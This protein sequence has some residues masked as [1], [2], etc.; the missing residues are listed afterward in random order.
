DVRMGGAA[1]Y[2]ERQRLVYATRSFL[3]VMDM[4]IFG[5]RD[6]AERRSETNADA[7]LWFFPR[8]G[9]AGIIERHPGGGDGELRVA[10]EALQPM[11][12][13]MIFRDPIP[14]FTAAMRIELGRIEA[15]DG[16]NAAF[17]RAE[18]APKV[19]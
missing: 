12:R 19:F 15:R 2:L 1:E 11:G 9:N 13:K 4:L 3:E 10:V 17:L 5:V 6:P 16:L 14:N 18:P 7:V 8:M